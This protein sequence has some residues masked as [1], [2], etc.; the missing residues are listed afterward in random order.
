MN[1][2]KVQMPVEELNRRKRLMSHWNAVAKTLY[3]CSDL[4]EIERI[5]YT[6]IHGLNRPYIIRRIYAHFNSV[7]RKAELIEIATFIK[8]VRHLRP[9]DF[10]APTES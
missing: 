4:D 5:L 9:E 6:E 10:D 3:A 8:N 7:R 2:E 1:L